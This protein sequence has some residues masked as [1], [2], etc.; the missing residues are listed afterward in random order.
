MYLYSYAVDTPGYFSHHHY[1]ETP[2]GGAEF[3][4]S[5]REIRLAVATRQM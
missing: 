3:E 2:A 1:Y 4:S 5:P